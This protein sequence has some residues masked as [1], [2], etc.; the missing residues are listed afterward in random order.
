LASG[1]QDPD[2]RFGILD[3]TDPNLLN[4]LGKGHG[5]HRCMVFL[6]PL[7]FPGHRFDA[8]GQI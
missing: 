8:L 2:N 6:W 1:Q 3:A 7:R 5:D 4:G